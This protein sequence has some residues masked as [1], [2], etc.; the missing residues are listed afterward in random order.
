MAVFLYLLARILFR[1]R[2]GRAAS[3]RSCV[4]LDGM[5]FVQSRIGMND[6]YVGLV[7]RRRLHRV[8]RRCGPGPGAAAAAF[9]IGCRIVGAVARPRPGLEV[10]RRLRDRRAGLL[11]L[12]RSALGRVAGDPGLIADDEPCSATSRISVPAGA[13]LG[14]LPFVAIMVGAA[15]SRPWSADVL[16]PI[17]LDARRG[18]GSRSCARSRCGGMQSLCRDRACGARGRR[19]TPWARLAIHAARRS[20]RCSWRW[21]TSRSPGCGPARVRR[22]RPRRAARVRPA[23]AGRP[24]RTTPTRSCRR[25]PRRRRGW[26][27]PGWAVGL[28]VVWVAA[29]LLVLPV[30]VY[31]VSYIPW[32]FIENHGLCEAWP[33]G[34][35]GQIA[36][37]PD[38]RDV[39]LPQQPDRAARR[40]IA[41][42]GLA[43]RPQAGLVLPGGLRRQHDAPRSTTPATS[44]SGGSALPALGFAAWQ[45][46]RRRS[47]AAGADRDRLR[48]PVGVLGADRPGGVPVPLL[49]EPAV[50]DPR[51]R[52]LP[53]RAVA[54]RRRGGPGCSPGSSAALAILAP[55]ALLA[56]RPAAVRVRR[57]RA[58]RT[59]AR[60]PARRSSPSSFSRPRRAAMADRRR[61]AVIVVVRLFGGSATRRRSWRRGPAAIGTRRPTSALGWPRRDG[62]GGDRRSRSRSGFLGARR[63]ADR[64]GPRSRSSRSRSSLAIPAA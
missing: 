29:C 36:R 18:R 32:A 7:H 34:H 27:R 2:L 39:R 8:R 49:H 1:R 22:V 15:R 48:V 19:S 12:V 45:A 44:S 4:V 17:G 40:V 46:F 58:G 51:P 5:L 14:N 13:G 42:V 41:V 31:V 35:T 10:G 25:R 20:G 52:L 56:L 53:G 59:R 55:G 37:R 21:S 9:W 28:P 43:V 50:P 6:V 30:A 11:I 47:L 3:S 54:R 57:R 16:H 62:G 24:P 38:R 61:V 26:L 60:R 63:A 33:H 23:R 64:R